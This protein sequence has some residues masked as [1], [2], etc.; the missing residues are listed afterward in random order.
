M[1]LS[2]VTYPKDT[3][4]RVQNLL[5]QEANRTSRPA[6][7]QHEP[8][9]SRPR[10]LVRRTVLLAPAAAVLA[11][12]L[13]ATDAVNLLWRPPATAEAVEALEGAAQQTINTSDPVLRPG[14]FLRVDTRAVYTDQ[15]DG[16]AGR[17]YW[18]ES[19][20]R[21]LYVPADKKAHWVM[22]FEESR[23]ISFF[24]EATAASV[25][26]I[27]GRTPKGR[28]ERGGLRQV[29]APWSEEELAALPLEPSKLLETIRDQGNSAD[30]QAFTWISDRLRTG[31]ITAQLRASL[32][33]AAALI[34][35]VTLVERRAALD[36]RSGVA[37][38]LVDRS[39]NT[40]REMIVDPNNGQ[41]IG[42]RVVDLDGYDAIP[43]GTATAWTA[44]KTSVVDTA[45]VTAQ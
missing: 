8:Q 21:Q 32:Y 18:L 26:E 11:G 35:G 27:E 41:F 44:V 36:G 12:G 16:G 43:P 4:N 5:V 25:L 45:P 15:G 42:E 14:Q 2:E 10:P 30:D 38:G 40:R 31:V 34:P 23:P 19:Q 37:I 28:N 1:N 13:V 22:K 33:R 29:D 3:K 20:D 24:G 7:Q 9:S 39:D 6:A 17:L